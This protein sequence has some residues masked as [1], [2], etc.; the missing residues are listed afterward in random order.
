[1]QPWFYNCI[2]VFLL[3]VF[4]SGI[5]I[6][7]ILLIAFRKKL[8]DEPDERK[9]HHSLVP[10]LG[11]I[12]FTP[13]IFFVSFL[14]VGLNL[15]F[16]H[17][18]ILTGSLADLSPILFGFSAM[19]LLYLVGIADDLIG[20][21]Y[22]AKFIAQVLC[23]VM[24]LT[25]GIW[26][27]DLHGT[28]GI[29]DIPSWVG[30]PLTVLAVVFIINA[31]NL[32]DGIDGL[33]SGLSGVACLVYGITFY[34]TSQY[35]YAMLAFATLGV[36]LPFFYYN[37]FGDASKRKKIF[38]GDTG[39]L[40]IG[41]VLAILSIRMAMYPLD[42]CIWHANPLVLG[43]APL[44]VPCCD[45]VRVYLHRVRNG[46]NPFLPDKNHIHHKLLAIGMPQRAAMISILV[47]TFIVV[48]SNIVVS[49]YININLLLLADVI[50]WI[51]GNIWLSRRAARR[52]A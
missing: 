19:L 40:T 48:V 30:Y 41:I 15:V 36:L 3:S 32:I 11:G 25:G 33:A 18:N 17:I 9:I 12:A 44:F 35:L 24:L 10:R 27:N 39:S 46:K 52:N 5:V 37:V 21:R 1:M 16:G 2:A 28:L 4:C 50:L 51:I 8:F 6:P 7:Q 42:E 31:I 49:R 20:V 43:F 14:L 29:H 22:R 47:S 38:M 26:I 23:A 13:V 34:M 45:V